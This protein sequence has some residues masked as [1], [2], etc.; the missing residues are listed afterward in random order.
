MNRPVSM[1]L[2]SIVAVL[3]GCEHPPASTQTLVVDPVPVARSLGRDELMQRQ[4]NS[5][6]EQLNTQLQ[7]HS[8]GLA[9]QVEQ[10]KEKLGKNPSEESLGKFREL[11]AAAS[12]NLQQTE[13]LAR[14][15]AA[16]YRQTLLGDFNSELRAAAMDIA[17]E[18]GA[19]SVLVV[20]PDM[21]WFDPAADIT[22]DVIARLRAKAATRSPSATTDADSTERRE[23]EKLEAV[24]ESIEK[25]QEARP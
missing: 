3:A 14:Q 6:L 15:K 5:A 22:A 12:Q 11:V 2:L 8:N 24:V 23:I 16:D 17:R 4:F 21:L 1:L 7:Q 18:R 13:L 25:Q 20:G 19:T 9:A 10:E